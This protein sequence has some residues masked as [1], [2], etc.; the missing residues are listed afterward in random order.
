[1]LLVSHSKWLESTLL[2][3]AFGSQSACSATKRSEVGST[4]CCY[5]RAR[6]AYRGCWP[7][8]PAAAWGQ[9]SHANRWGSWAVRT[10]LWQTKRIERCESLLKFCEIKKRELRLQKSKWWLWICEPCTW[11]DCWQK[12]WAFS[13]V[14]R[15]DPDARK[16]LFQC[17]TALVT[18]EKYLVDKSTGKVQTFSIAWHEWASDWSCYRNP[19][20]Q[21]YILA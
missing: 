13:A 14:C 1:M 7:G 3:S 5:D 10:Y 6:A 18:E 19:P 17:R 8:P 20:T 2:C 15:T 11:C 16:G 12:A 9:V 4:S 21:I